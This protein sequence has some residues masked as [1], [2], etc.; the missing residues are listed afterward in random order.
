MGVFQTL[1]EAS[2]VARRVGGRAGRQA[3]KVAM[4]Q[5]PIRRQVERAQAQYAEA[6]KAA[7]AQLKDIEGELWE[8][9]ERLKEKAQK[10]ARQ[11]ERRRV[12]ADHYALLGIQPGA[13][14]KAVKVAW[15]KKMREHHPDRFS[16]DAVAERQ[17][18]E[19]AQRINAA[20]NELTALLSG[21]ESRRAD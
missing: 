17:A 8:W 6:R 1:R 15:R 13:D 16:G 11:A 4:K 12:S 19:Q 21:R 3:A 14:L 20:Y 18:H 9:I 10:A 7:E 5:P 2:R